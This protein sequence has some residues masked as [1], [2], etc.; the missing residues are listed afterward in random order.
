MRKVYIAIEI[1]CH[2][3]G[4]GHEVIGTYNAKKTAQSHADER[5]D[6]RDGGQ[7]IPAVF[8]VEI[9][10]TGLRGLRQNAARHR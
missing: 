8:E 9:P 1:G 4:V 3:C 10:F 2:E 5:G 7:S 6:W